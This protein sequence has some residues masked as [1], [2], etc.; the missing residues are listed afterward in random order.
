MPDPLGMPDVSRTEPLWDRVDRNRVKL[1]LFV[2]A[3]VLGSVFSLDFMLALPVSAF[4][5]LQTL[6]DP[7]GFWDE[8]PRLFPAA[9]L[10]TVLAFLLA[11]VW[12]SFALLQSE[13]RLL[14][15]LGA[16]AV[17]PGELMD[18][19]YVLKDMGLAGGVVPA[20][21]LFLMETANVNA[22]VLA[23]RHHRAAVGV[24]RGFVEK[25]SADEQRAA[26]ANLIARIVNG[27]VLYSTGITA[28]VWP[29]HAFREGNLSRMNRDVDFIARQP[30]D[31]SGGPTAFPIA[32][33]FVLIWA[34]MLAA[35]IEFIAFG[36]REANL[37]IAEKADAEG[38]LLLKDPAP[39]LAALEKGVR[40]DN[41]I[42][43]S[44]EALANLFWFWTGPASDDETDFE[45]QRVVKL[46]EVLG[47]EGSALD[48]KRQQ[49]LD[50]AVA[51]NTPPAPP[52]L[53]GAR[54]DAGGS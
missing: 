38:M 29:I 17:P 4:L 36:S 54:G 20:P 6:T 3:F 50:S 37:D 53:D 47:V 43:A 18:T 12:A 35:S 9:V 34:F 14:R 1:A 30:D 2:A 24:T 46:R 27:D 49:Q 41:Y 13:R 25:L 39:M 31:E 32:G 19:K 28:L 21:E 45:Y 33:F 52:R 26:F 23:V 5:L 40:Y 8:M 7:V 42:P 10:L 11:V 48:A 22:F 44:G 15:R 51:A 16:T